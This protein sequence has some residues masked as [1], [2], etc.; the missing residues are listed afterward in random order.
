MYFL[1]SWK[2][3]D[4]SDW[5]HYYDVSSYANLTVEQFQLIDIGYL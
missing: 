4:M 1:A 3:P 5:L 2:L